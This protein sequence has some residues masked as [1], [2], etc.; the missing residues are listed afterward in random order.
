MGGVV[1]QTP[2]LLTSVLLILGHCL[3]GMVYGARLVIRWVYVS[4]K[5]TVLDSVDIFTELLK[6]SVRGFD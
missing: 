4:Q 2:S 3:S 6:Y 1:C 5:M